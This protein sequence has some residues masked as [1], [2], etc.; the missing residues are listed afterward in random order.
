VDKPNTNHYWSLKFV[1]IYKYI[2]CSDT[3]YNI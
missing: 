1:V 2:F 3:D